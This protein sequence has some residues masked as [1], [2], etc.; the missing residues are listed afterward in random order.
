MIDVSGPWFEDLY[1]GLEFDAPPITLTA[2][3]AAVYGGLFGDRLR[4]PLDHA[5]GRAVTGCEAPLADPLLVIN[6]AIGQT[7]WATQRVKANLYLPRTAARGHDYEP[8]RRTC[9]ALLALSDDSV[10]GC[11][12]RDGGC[13]RPRSDRQRTVACG[14]ARGA[15]SLERRR[16]PGLEGRGHC[17]RSWSTAAH[18][19][20]RHC[21]RRAR[22][23]SADAE[24]GNGPH[25]CRAFVPWRAPRLWWAYHFDGLRAGD[26]R[27][28]RPADDGGV[29]ALRPHGTG[30]RERPAAHRSRSTRTHRPALGGALLKLRCET[31]ATRATGG[32]ESRVLDW[33]FYAWS[34]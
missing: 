18:R 10:P 7:T 24:H 31:F 21:H 3:H 2:G 5:A 15:L 23:R 19:S 29:G 22:V 16:L 26:P 17:G 30:A 33:T 11:R 14:V 8:A 28:A 34:L 13:R 25:R 20:S 6:A 1:C 4:L 12:R 27:P 9:A 32:D